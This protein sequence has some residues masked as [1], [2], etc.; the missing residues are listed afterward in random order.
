MHTTVRIHTACGSLA[1]RNIDAPPELAQSMDLLWQLASDAEKRSPSVRLNAIGALASIISLDDASYEK[2]KTMLKDV[3]ALLKKHTEGDVLESSTIA[4]LIN[5]TVCVHSILQNDPSQAY[6]A[7]EYGVLECVDKHLIN[8]PQSQVA[9]A[10]ADL[11]CQMAVTGDA[12]SEAIGEAGILPKI[13]TFVSQ[14]LSS[15]PETTGFPL[16]SPQL[17]AQ[18]QFPHAGKLVLETKDGE[19]L[20]K[21]MLLL[22]MLCGGDNERNQAILVSERPVLKKIIMLSRAQGEGADQDVLHI[23]KSLFATIGKNATLRGKLAD[24]LREVAEESKI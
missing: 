20:C 1:E 6:K 16:S 14:Y 22:G 2:G 10:A 7:I 9:D 8:H 24:A 23:A 21:C 13:G 4:L 3:V 12:C 18:F 5:T 15:P 11:L 19:T 17:D